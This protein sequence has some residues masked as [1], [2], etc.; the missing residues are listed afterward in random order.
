MMAEGQ[1]SPF[2]PFHI[3]FPLLYQSWMQLTFI[4]WIYPVEVLERFVPS[5]LKIDTL[6]DKAYVGMVAFRQ[7]GVRFSFLPPLPG[8]ALFPETNLRTYV[9]SPN[10]QRGVWFFSCDVASLPYALGGKMSFAIPHPWDHME[11]TQTGREIKYVAKRLWPK[12]P[13]ASH[14][15]HM[16]IGN[17]IPLKDLK[18]L[19][20]FLTARYRLFVS[21]AG[22]LIGGRVEHT[23]YPLFRARLLS[24]QQTL[25]TAAGLPEPKGE[26]LV[27]YSSGVRTRIGLP[28][29]SGRPGGR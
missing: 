7:E 21:L 23:P 5:S 12:R 4:H 16:E 6:D 15:I 20:L 26:P 29:L 17:E 28:E 10:G 24:L 25:T 14:Q 19:D 11:M 1:L 18:D 22:M 2:V 13:E 8:S 9:R 27:L 3:K